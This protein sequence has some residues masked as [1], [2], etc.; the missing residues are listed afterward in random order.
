MAWLNTLI[1][2]KTAIRFY[3][4]FKSRY[5]PSDPSDPL[6]SYDSTR[7]R[8]TI[9]LTVERYVGGNETSART[10]AESLSSDSAYEEA[11]AIP[12]A[13]GQWHVQATRKTE[14]DWVEEA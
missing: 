8:R 6:S 4:E 3:T 9:C 1:L 11:E 5:V 10:L 14:G 7:Y 13:G 12:M 2:T